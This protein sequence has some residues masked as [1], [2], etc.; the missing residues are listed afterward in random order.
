MS[1][2]A[3][4][5]VFFFG[6][7]ASAPFR[8]PT[9]KQ[10]VVDFEKFLNE[11]GTER[12]NETY[13]DVKH[14]LTKQL[15][16][17]I[18]L[19]D[20][21]TVVDGCIHLDQERLGSLSLY[22]FPKFLKP[23]LKR[24]D[25]TSFEFELDDDTVKN[26]ET[27]VDKFQKFVREKCLIPPE[28]FNDISKVYRDFFNRIEKEATSIS[29]SDRTKGNYRYNEKW[30]MF[31]TNYDI[32]LEY[33][34]REVV[35]V[36]L[37][38]GFDFDRAR[39]AQVLK[40]DLFHVT[41]RPNEMRLLKLHGS[42]SWRVEEDGTVIEDTTRG[43]SLMGRKY[44]GELMIYPIEQKELYVNPYISMFLDLN[45]ELKN[46]SIWIIIGYSFNDPVI[47][48]IF[49]RNS[50]ETKRIVLI[51]PHAKRVKE[52]RLGNIKCKEM[53][54]LEQKFGEGD[55]RSLDYLLIQKL[56]PNPSLQSS[57]EV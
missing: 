43:E 22:L 52:Q 46:K 29:G 37:N 49:I 2:D 3:S 11:N 26:F 23:I 31:T 54:L 51:H 5:I 24:S 32:C 38:T 19:E 14:V 16:R 41:F 8:I 18:D 28:S 35:R 53:F 27:L 33:Y 1:F 50:D 56:K 20:V 47:R 39:N 15:D 40:P 6:A 21:F 42:I 57:D 34:W 30:A 12:E 36:P 9:M 13:H 44:V 4:N 17:E 55:F 25:P 45:R 7:G 10:F 48:E